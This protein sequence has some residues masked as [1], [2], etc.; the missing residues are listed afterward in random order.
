MQAAIEREVASLDDAARTLV[1]GA[2]VAGDPFD[3]ELAATAAGVAAAAERARRAGAA[4]LVR[5]SGE[6]REFAFRHPLV[7][8]AIYDATPPAWR[9]AAHERVA[10]AL[11]AR[12]ADAAK[13]AYHVARFARAGDTEAVALLRRAAEA[14][15]R[16]SP[17]TAANWYAA[18]LPLVRETARGEILGPLALSLASAGRLE[19]S[20]ERLDEA[21]ALAPGDLELILACARVEVLRGRFAHGPPPAR[22][23]LRRPAARRAWP[24]SWPRRR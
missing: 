16:T 17:A 5:R 8:R 12:G 19:A 21:L 1:R 2:A 7:R 15:A 14:A 22:G 3:P 13:R 24:S 4:D 20:Q 9:L 18:A 11:E 10:A 23:R 6:A